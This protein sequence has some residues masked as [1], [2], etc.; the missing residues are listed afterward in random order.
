MEIVEAPPTGDLVTYVHGE[1]AR[2]LA[3]HVPVLVYVGATW[4][5][6]CREFHA[7]AEAGT[8]DAALGPLRLLEFDVDRDGTYLEAAGYRSQLVPL[9]ARPG[10][11]GRASGKQIEGARKGG[12]YVREL[13]PRVRE[14][15]A[16]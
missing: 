9:F 7:A 2:G 14:L 16:R 4:C 12:D 5:E 10:S 6:P 15:L 13:T 3:E 8:L 1:V 11:D